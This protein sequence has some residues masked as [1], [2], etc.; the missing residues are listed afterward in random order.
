MG[1]C[2]SCTAED[3]SKP[4]EVTDPLTLNTPDMLWLHGN[5]ASHWTELL[6]SLEDAADQPLFKFPR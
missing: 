4:V 6:G 1:S 3:P 2:G 5:D